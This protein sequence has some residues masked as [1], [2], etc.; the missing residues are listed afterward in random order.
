MSSRLSS[1]IL[2]LAAAMLLLI[3]IGGSGW[4][5]GHPY[6]PTRTYTQIAHVGLHGA[7]LCLVDQAE[8]ET[9]KD[10]P[11][12]SIFG[13]VGYIELIACLLLLLS[14]VGLAVLTLQRKEERKLFG[15][16]VL[17][18]AALGDVLAFAL[19]AIGPTSEATI[20][21]G[22][23]LWCFF[24]GSTGGLVAAL[25]ARR[26]EAPVVTALT[27]VVYVPPPATA[28][29]QQ[30]A[31]DYA[32]LMSPPSPAPQDS[33]LFQSAPQL[34]PL[35]EVQGA[36]PVPSPPKFP[37]RA[38]TPMPREQI[39]AATGRAES[40]R[41]TTVPPPFSRPMP[42]APR[43]LFG[44]DVKPLIQPPPIA[45]LK[46]KPLFGAMV[47]PLTQPPPFAQKAL[48]NTKPIPKQELDEP[49]ATDTDPGGAPVVVPDVGDSTDVNVPLDEAGP[50]ATVEAPSRD[51]ATDIATIAVEKFSAAELD[52]LGGKHLPISTA[53]AELPPPAEVKAGGPSPACPQCEAPMAWVEE[54]LRFYCKSCRMYF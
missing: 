50:V 20:P 52:D 31:Y 12:H 2:A 22:Y 24:L 19:M 54:H 9:C 40:P 18:G 44:S 49:R 23:G 17:G 32:A 15:L 30:P 34:R 4:W 41:P 42:P 27:P 10:A 8:L 45:P 35:Y 21:F 6:S 47:K 14:S 38:P 48:Y 11:T 43:P 29:Q 3:S 39:A 5:T 1:A 33:P 46:P 25:I 37:T 28:S 51:S 53:P 13:A 26:D 36:S 16:L 7:K